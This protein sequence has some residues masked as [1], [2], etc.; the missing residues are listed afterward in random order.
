MRVKY[1]K[2]NNDFLV[3]NKFGKLNKKELTILLTNLAIK[4]PNQK[5]I[6]KII[7]PQTDP[8]DNIINRISISKIGEEFFKINSKDSKPNYLLPCIF[9]CSDP[10]YRNSYLMSK[11]PSFKIPEISNSNSNIIFETVYGEE[12]SSKKLEK[13]YLYTGIFLSNNIIINIPLE[14]FFFPRYFSAY[15]EILKVFYSYSK[16]LE[17]NCMDN[18]DKKT[19]FIA[20]HGVDQDFSTNEQDKLSKEIY[21]FVDE[22]KKN[23]IQLFKKSAQGSKMFEY[24]EGIIN[25][26]IVYLPNKKHLRE[27]FLEKTKEIGHKIILQK[28]Q[29]FWEHEILFGKPGK[30]IDESNFI[31]HKKFKKTIEEFEKFEKYIHEYP[32]NLPFHLMTS[33][34][35]ISEIVCREILENTSS[36]IHLI[37][38]PWIDVVKAG[39]VQGL[40][41]ELNKLWEKI[42]DFF[43]N[44]GK[45]FKKTE[46]FSRKSKI[47]KEGFFLDCRQLWSYQIQHLS[48]NLMICFRSAMGNIILDDNLERNLNSL[49][50]VFENEFVTMAESSIPK[51]AKKMWFYPYDKKNFKKNM[52]DLVNEKIKMNYYK[53]FIVKKPKQPLSIWFH[54]LFPHP[55]G[56][57]LSNEPLGNEDSFLFERKKN[58]AELK[59]ELMRYII[60]KPRP[61]WTYSNKY[62]AILG[63]LEEEEY[64]FKEKPKKAIKRFAK[65]S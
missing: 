65:S 22:M 58:R 32:K 7:R 4:K 10:D 13:S 25:F 12:Y 50:A 38:P 11:D 20:I 64:I 33:M 30:I 31:D 36:I 40:G 59:A 49:M 63:N 48:Q 47:L 2:R 17:K 19:F 18:S 23:C 39:W 53:G 52:R 45:F 51:F 24:K 57:D 5:D 14:E 3:F 29:T 37:F 34:S 44:E 43:N 61:T 8:L 35:I 28:R 42:E 62:Q 21:N 16:A 41:N 9:N 6:F 26:Q 60:Q 46:A 55:F 56:K 27:E 15:D 1:E 54:A